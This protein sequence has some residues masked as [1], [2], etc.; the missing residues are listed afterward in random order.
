MTFWI[1]RLLVI[2][3]APTISWFQVEK[4]TKGLIIGVGIALL[5]IGAELLIQRIALDTLIFAT[6]GAVS[7][8]LLSVIIENVASFVIKNDQVT[9]FFKVY[10]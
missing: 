5:I 9:Y 4:S 2:V 3:A 10:L 6:V 7:G 1:I 8:L